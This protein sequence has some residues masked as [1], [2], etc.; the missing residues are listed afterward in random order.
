MQNCQC[1]ASTL[2]RLTRKFLESTLEL[3]KLYSSSSTSCSVSQALLPSVQFTS[4]LKVMQD[5]S[6]KNG[7]HTGRHNVCNVSSSHI[8]SQQVG[9]LAG[10]ADS[11]QTAV[12]PNLASI[13]IVQC[14]VHTGPL[15][16][17]A[18]TYPSWPQLKQLLHHISHHFAF[19]CPHLLHAPDSTRTGNNV[20]VESFPFNRDTTQTFL[21]IYILLFS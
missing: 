6:S 3:V 5:I 9:Q 4:R 15:V 11:E 14:I 12:W 18:Q 1:F 8:H 20:W 7:S 19:L 21:R 2:Y 17:F 16:A 10:R 13:Y